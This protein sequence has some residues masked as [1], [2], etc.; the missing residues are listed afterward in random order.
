M[1]P[2]LINTDGAGL[3]KIGWLA[4]VYAM[5]WG[6]CQLWTGR[7]AD[8]I[9]RKRPVVARFFLLAGGIALI[10]L[11]QGEGPRYRLLRS[12]GSG[13]RSCI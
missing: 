8:R 3:V 7:L 4:G 6:L 12:W 13:W 2:V 10:A 1:L 11:G 9:G 5:I